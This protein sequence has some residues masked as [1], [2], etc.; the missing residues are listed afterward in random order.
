MFF[1]R[2][3]ILELTGR[4]QVLLMNDTINFK[5]SLTFERSVFFYVT[6]TGNLERFQYFSFETNFLKNANLP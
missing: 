4:T 5:N 3:F 2:G 6:I 1:L